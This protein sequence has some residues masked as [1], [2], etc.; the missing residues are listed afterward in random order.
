MTY[1]NDTII[2]TI[3]KRVSPLLSGVDNVNELQVEMG[4]DL[5]TLPVLDI[6]Q[7]G[8]LLVSDKEAI[9]VKIPIGAVGG[10]FKVS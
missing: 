5:D 6:A 2:W 10:S 9:T 8:Y 7:R 1:S 3:P 4:I